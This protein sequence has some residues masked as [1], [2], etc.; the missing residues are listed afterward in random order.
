M[1]KRRRDALGP[2]KDIIIR[3][4][5][6]IAGQL[7][8]VAACKGMTVQ[9]YCE[10]VIVPQIRKDMDERGLSAEQISR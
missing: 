1:R 9:D 3:L 2:R 5:E 7:K 10:Q 6:Q 8:V 4:P